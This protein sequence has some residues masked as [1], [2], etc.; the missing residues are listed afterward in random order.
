MGLNMPELNSV[1]RKTGELRAQQ[2]QARTLEA[3]Q[4]NAL[5]ALGVRRVIIIHP[6]IRHDAR[7]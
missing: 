1:H 4:P 3:A 2:H 5:A 6:F 7:H